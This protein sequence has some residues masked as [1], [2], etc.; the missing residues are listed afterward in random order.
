MVK[1]SDISADADRA[2]RASPEPANSLGHTATIPDAGHPIA[3]IAPGGCA[4]YLTPG[5]EYLGVVF[6]AG[7]FEIHDDDGAELFCLF[8]GCAHAGGHDWLVQA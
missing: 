5:K 8:E 7:A 3:V 1:S 4:S 6:S 2:G